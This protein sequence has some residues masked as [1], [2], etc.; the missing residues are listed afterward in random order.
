MTLALNPHHV[1]L[2]LTQQGYG[3]VDLCPTHAM[4]QIWYSPIRRETR[5]ESLAVTLVSEH[6]SSLWSSAEEPSL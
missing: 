4:A 3:L 1:C 2:E 5:E 6:G